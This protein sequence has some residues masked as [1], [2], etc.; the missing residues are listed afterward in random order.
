VEKV[1]D[2]SAA[3]AG[4]RRGDVILAVNGDKAGSVRQ[5]RSL[6]AKNG[7]RVALLILRGE[8]QLFVPL[9]MG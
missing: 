9:N 2:G 4:I 1:A 3:K 8:Q 7:Q 6:I 5:L